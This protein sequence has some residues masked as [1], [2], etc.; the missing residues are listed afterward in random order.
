M[1]VGRSPERRCLQLALVT[2]AQGAKIKTSC[3]YEY[4]NGA[5]LARA[6]SHGAV[7][8]IHFRARVAPLPEDPFAGTQQRFDLEARPEVGI[9]PTGR[10]KPGFARVA[11]VV[12]VEAREALLRLQRERGLPTMSQALRA[13]L[14]EWLEQR[15]ERV[16]HPGLAGGDG[17]ASASVPLPPNGRP[18]SREASP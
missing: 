7:P 10:L 12:S 15:R 16:L 6:R 5:L 13:A 18:P 4:A 1:G 2:A 3:V 8:S 9:A 14:Q 11:G 17:E